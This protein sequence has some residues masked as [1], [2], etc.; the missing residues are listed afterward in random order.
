VELQL[1]AQFNPLKVL[2]VEDDV[3]QAG[4]VVAILSESDCK[5]QHV[6]DGGDAIRLATSLRPHLILIDLGLPTIDG[7]DTIRQIRRLPLSLSPYIVAISGFTDLR[8]R[9][10]AFEAGCDE[11]VVK[12]FDA[13]A[14][15]RTFRVR[16]AELQAAR[17]G[18]V[19]A[20]P[21]DGALPAARRRP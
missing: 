19:T 18:I 6:P 12:P 3:E 8:S 14:V 2:L 21:D 1:T 10:L 4:R 11:Y 16:T 15:L 9:E 5:V 13:A 7:W 20:S 17:R